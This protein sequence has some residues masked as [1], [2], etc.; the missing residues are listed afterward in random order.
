MSKVSYVLAMFYFNGWQAAD[1]MKKGLSIFLDLYVFH[2]PAAIKVPHVISI[3]S[4]LSC[5]VAW[6]VLV[7]LLKGCLLS[8][9][10]PN[11][12]TPKC[13]LDLNILLDTYLWFHG[14]LFCMI[15][16]LH[17]GP[18][19]WHGNPSRRLQNVLVFLAWNN[20]IGRKH[21]RLQLWLSL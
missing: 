17:S 13:T 11:H 5:Q 12:G 6:R 21:T 8:S 18:Q 1:G 15:H 4:S 10:P 19:H 20:I 2:L 7:I 3:L 14:G 16:L 9:T